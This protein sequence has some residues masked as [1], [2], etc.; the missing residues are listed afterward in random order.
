MT[1]ATLLLCLLLSGNCL[2][3]KYVPGTP[4][5]DWS[6]QE[7][8]AV[9]SKLYAVFSLN[10]GYKAVQEIHGDNNGVNWMDVPDAAKML[11]LGE[12]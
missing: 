1:A 11:R 5:A 4:G 10:G 6:P 7:V 8:L 9:K 12:S 3:L 2:S